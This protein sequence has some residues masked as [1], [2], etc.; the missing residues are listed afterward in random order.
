[1][2]KI[3]YR[4]Y[5]ELLENPETS[6]ETLEK[7]VILA[8]GES[9]F[10]LSVF[11]NPE[12]VDV[13]DVQWE[14]ENALSIGNDISR[15]RRQ[16]KF[17]KRIKQGEQLPIIVSEGDSWFQFPIIIKDVVDHLKQD[18]LIYSVGAAGDTAQN[19]V[20]GDIDSKRTEYMQAISKLRDDNLTVDGLMFSAAGNDIIGTNK[21]TG[22]SSLFDI[23]KPFNGDANDIVG[24]INFSIFVNKLNFLQTAYLKVISTI[25]SDPTISNIPIFVHGYDYVFPHPWENDER[26]PKYAAKNE[27]L[28]DPLD[29]RGIMDM[30]LR[31]NI[32][33]FLLDHLHDMLNSLAQDS[34]QTNVWVIDCRGVMDDLTD[35]NDEIHGTS[36]GFEKIAGEFRNVMD[37]VLKP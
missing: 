33:K 18:Y 11:P 4:E 8:R 1:M 20:F 12:T 7:Y 3:T 32:I 5:R 23:L 34:N 37:A 29:E 17:K 26:N 6:D 14:L 10:E 35:W 2:E 16:Q 25:R 15:W 36:S 21:E 13:S 28:G 24:H 27:W 30:Q 9:G 19:M 22:K 31:R